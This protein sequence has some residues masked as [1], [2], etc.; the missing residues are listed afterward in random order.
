MEVLKLPEFG[1]TI[2]LD[3]QTNRAFG[4]QTLMPLLRPTTVGVLSENKH[5]AI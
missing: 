2:K 3:Q 4:H 5:G 1:S